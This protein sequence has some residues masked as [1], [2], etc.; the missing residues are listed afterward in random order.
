MPTLRIIVDADSCPVKK[1]IISAS[2]AFAVEVVFVASYAHQLS[3]EGT[4]VSIV[5][6]DPSDQSADLYIANH[7][8]SGDILITGDFGL[9]ALGL[10]KG[11]YVLS[12]GGQQF[13]DHNI[14]SLLERRHIQAKWR[15]SGYYGKGPKPFTVNQKNLFLQSL[16]KLLER[17]QEN[18]FL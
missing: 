12:P 9:A 13:T 15:R 11:A 14:D 10:A 2:E 8:S 5:Q 3:E 18:T 6:V 17:L 7:L 4:R 1:E 16:T